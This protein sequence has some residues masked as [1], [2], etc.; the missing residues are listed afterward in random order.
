[1]YNYKKHVGIYTGYNTTCV[2]RGLS[3]YIHISMWYI[4]H[5]HIIYNMNYDANITH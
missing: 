2:F 5:I 4:W 3:G 1:M